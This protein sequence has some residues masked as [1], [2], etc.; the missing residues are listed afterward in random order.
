MIT[1][2]YC[3]VVHWCSMKF[4]CIAEYWL[5]FSFKADV[6]MV[7]GKSVIVFFQPRVLPSGATVFI[8][9]VESESIRKQNR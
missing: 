7:V 6:T 4:M 2:V 5:N 1:A 8:C 9:A 3:K